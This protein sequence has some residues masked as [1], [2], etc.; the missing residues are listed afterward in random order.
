MLTEVRVGPIVATDGAPAPARAGKTGE[1]IVGD[2]HGRYHEAVVRGNVFTA[3]NQASTT[4]T[5][6]GTTAATGFTLANPTGS[7]KYLSLLSV[8]YAKVTAAAAAIESLVISAGINQN[9]TAHTV[10]LTVANMLIGSSNASVAKADASSTLP[11]AGVI[12]YAFQSPSV[13]ATATTGVPPVT[14]VDFGGLIIV[15]PGSF[16]QLAA[17]FTNTLA[18]IAHMVWEEVAII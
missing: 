9:I 10:A 15:S 4:F 7:G 6:F 12:I 17:G 5:L 1:L 14:V 11:A 16:I 8:G 18:G 3:A 13:S 2:A